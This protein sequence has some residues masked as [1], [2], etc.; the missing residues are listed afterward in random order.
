MI[1]KSIILSLFAVLALSS[2]AEIK[3][4]FDKPTDI[5]N[6]TI[7]RYSLDNILTA[8]S[9]SELIPI[10][11]TITA[12]NGSFTYQTP[13]TWA[14]QYI[15]NLPD[16]EE[17]ITYFFANP[18]DNVE[19][20]IS[21]NQEGLYQAVATGTELLDGIAEINKTTES[22]TQRL[23]AIRQ[24][25]NTTE[26]FDNLYSEYQNVFANYV[27][28]NPN[29]QAA[30]YAILYTSEEDFINLFD[31]LGENAKNSIYY[32]IAKQEQ[33]RIAERLQKI[34]Q[35]KELE[36]GNTQAPEFSLPGLNGNLISLADYRGKW[37]ILD[38]W[39]SWCGWCIKGFPKMKEYY[40]KF[41]D[42]VEFIGIDCGDTLEQWKS[43]VKKYEIPWVNVYNDSA[44]QSPDRVDLAYGI[45]GFPTKIIISP[46]GKI[47]RII[48][49]EDP[50]FYTDLESFLKEE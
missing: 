20:V 47:K 46:D 9:R 36:S 28:N 29:N 7:T 18:T 21:Q 1:K 49:G 2:T 30:A 11:D 16:V 10:S 37:V 5:N 38:F 41:A 43:A 35:Q 27:R 26:N 44:N 34:R 4:S 39:G 22:I 15:I 40:A 3:I 24:G 32:P 6:I 8:K 50:Q 13:S 31:T 17:P 19:V 25:L 42:K 33:P 23:I 45:Q 12:E 48:V 14:E